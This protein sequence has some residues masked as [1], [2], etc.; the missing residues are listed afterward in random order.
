MTIRFEQFLSMLRLA[1]ETYAAYLPQIL[2]LAVLGFLSGL[3][4]GIGVNA[5]IPLLAILTVSASGGDD[6]ISQAIERFFSLLGIDFSLKF[7][8]IF[9]IL[10]FILKATV[11]LLFNY[12][13]IKISSGD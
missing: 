6:P 1:R 9:I 5:L 3:F 12:I 8:L 13:K 4:E 11:L 7:I 10:L 2:A